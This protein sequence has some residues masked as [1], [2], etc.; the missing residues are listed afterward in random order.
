MLKIINQFGFRAV[1]IM[2]CLKHLNKSLFTVVSIFAIIEF[3]IVCLF[4]ISTRVQLAIIPNGKTKSLISSIV[5]NNN[6][7]FF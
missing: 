6:N 7:D 5:N 1:I 3:T 2:G 4:D